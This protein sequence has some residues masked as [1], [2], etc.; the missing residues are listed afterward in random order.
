MNRK[1]IWATA[2]CF[3]QVDIPILER[4]SHSFDILW[5]VNVKKGSFSIKT[6]KGFAKSCG[7]Q[8]RLFEFETKWYNPKHF[9][10]TNHYIK[11]IASEKADIYYLDI[12]TFFHAIRPIKKHLKGKKV[13]IALHQGKAHSGM[14]FRRIHNKY[15]NW[16][17][18]QPYF[19]KFF[20]KSQELLFEAPAE[21]KYLSPLVVN[22]FGESNVLPSKEKVVFQYFG[23]IIST[24]NVGLL[25]KAACILKETC[26]RPFVVR[27]FGN[28]RKWECLYQPLVRY[29]DIFELRIERI[30]DY[31]IPDIFSS[32]H[33]LVLPYSS[34]SQSGPLRIAY[35]YNL[36][37]I[38]SDLDGFKESI[39]D[40]VSGLLFASNNVDA[41]IQTMKDCIVNH[42][43]KW[44]E[45]KQHQK[46]Y[47]DKNLT[48]EPVIHQYEEMFDDVINK[49]QQS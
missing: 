11:S 26:D 41:L 16:L 34:V 14:R 10:E 15:L 35:G 48:I 39:E 31:E 40:N 18:K 2:E 20:S 49:N 30:P 38:A 44:Q 21:R 37:V 22:F 8:F 42:P 4:L 3:L 33:Y 45:L 25:I 7:I 12:P 5:M 13:I 1:I 36:P 23:N 6:A 27:I 29:P 17:G 9:I 46:A 28:C 43:T 24:K 47:V 32:S 19:F